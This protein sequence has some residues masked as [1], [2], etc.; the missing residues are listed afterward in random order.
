[1]SRCGGATGTASFRRRLAPIMPTRYSPDSLGLAVTEVIDD[2]NKHTARRLTTS[3]IV[4][5]VLYEAAFHRRIAAGGVILALGSTLQARTGNVAPQQY[6]HQVLRE[7]S[8]DHVPIH[9]LDALSEDEAIMLAYCDSS[10]SKIDAVY[11]SADQ[12]VE[13][14]VRSD[15]IA[16][17]RLAI[18]DGAARRL[19]MFVLPP[20]WRGLLDAYD[21]ACAAVHDAAPVAEQRVIEGYQRDAATIRRAAPIIV[22]RRDPH[23]ADDYDL[24]RP[25]EQVSFEQWTTLVQQKIRLK[26]GVQRADLRQR[27]ANVRG[28]LAAEMEDEVDVAMN[29]L[30][31]FG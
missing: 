9:L 14:A 4:L 5:H 20:L 1:M 15:Y 28:L 21:C 11:N 24:V 8:I 19:S 10:V 16:L 25:M 30:G 22:R 17:A 7:L 26:N 31:L 2:A 3:F 29:R 13:Q 27:R 6:A 18:D 23:V 12:L